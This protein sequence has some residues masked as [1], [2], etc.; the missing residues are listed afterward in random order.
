M[1]IEIESGRI[2]YIGDI[3]IIASRKRVGQN[4]SYRYEYSDATVDYASR[5]YEDIFAVTTLVE[6]RPGEVPVVMDAAKD[7]GKEQVDLGTGHR[8]RLFGQ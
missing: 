5:R 7:G 8:S 4:L 6:S 2:N 3:E 1:A